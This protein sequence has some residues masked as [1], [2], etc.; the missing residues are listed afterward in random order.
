MTENSVLYVIDLDRTLLNVD[1][2]ME[3]VE[4]VCI[5]IDIDYENIKKAQRIVAEAGKSYSPIETIGEHGEE[6]LEQ[7][8]EKFV[9]TA[10]AKELIYP[11]GK[12][13]LDKLESVSA[14]Y[15]ILTY[16]LNE[17]W[18]RL[19]FEAAEL[20]QIPHIITF[21]SDKD[22]QLASWQSE[23]GVFM[24]PV[25]GIKP[26]QKLVFIDDRLRVFQ[27]LPKNCEG[28]RIKR[29][30]SLDEEGVLPHGVRQIASFDEIIDKV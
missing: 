15:I 16:A 7:F 4:K 22:R 1:K 10:N 9:E 6:K 13:Y 27:N 14:Q 3:L 29:S 24:A 12:R 19:K 26:A 21:S 25:T 17:E 18:Q 2:V 5:Q 20:A 30:D 11:D 8:R 28:Y 23:D